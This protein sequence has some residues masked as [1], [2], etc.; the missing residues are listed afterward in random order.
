MSAGPVLSLIAPVKDEEAAIGPF[1][2][3]IEPIL[4]GLFPDAKAPSWEILFVDRKSV[5]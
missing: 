5:V 2:D 1:L 3:R 4:D